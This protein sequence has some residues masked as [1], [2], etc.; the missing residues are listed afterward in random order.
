MVIPKHSFLSS[1]DAAGPGSSISIHT[2]IYIYH[3]G[4]VGA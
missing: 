1:S 2:Y 3:L 4:V